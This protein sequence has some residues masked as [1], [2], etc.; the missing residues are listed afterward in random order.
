MTAI[1]PTIAWVAIIILALLTTADIIIRVWGDRK[2]LPRDHE[3]RLRVRAW[4]AIVAIMGVAVILGKTALF[5]LLA[6]ISFLAL[7]EFFAHFPD[8]KSN[9]ILV[10]VAYLSIPFQYYWASIAWYGMFITFIPVYLF[11]MIPMLKVL[12]DKSEDFLR[13]VAIVQWGIMI[14]VFSL[15]HA[16]FL[17]ALPEA[18]SPTSGIGLLLFLV[19]LTE[20]N[21]VAQ[22]LWG[23]ALGRRKILPTVSPRKTW[24]GL[25]GG[26]ST[27]VLLAL[28]AGPWLTPLQGYE[29]PVAGL[30]IGIF[31]FIG[32]VTFSAIKRDHNIKDSGNLLPGHGG[33]LDRVDSL[34]FTA[35]LFFYYVYLLHY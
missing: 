34:T 28:V 31:G 11:L 22:Y 6:F 19:I 32:D 15:S 12:G 30:L 26:V 7:R 4:W 29:I 25:I 13:S 5:C 33:I 18:K 10:V 17:L 21:D 27:T 1:P 23:K 2:Q 20:L 3:L 9:R 16:A 24:A 14:T 8:R 35:P